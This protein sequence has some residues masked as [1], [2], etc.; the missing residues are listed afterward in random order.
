MRNGRMVGHEPRQNLLGHRLHD[1]TS[2]RS[3]ESMNA[4]IASRGV[5]PP[6]FPVGDPAECRIERNGERPIRPSTAPAPAGAQ[7]SRCPEPRSRSACSLRTCRSRSGRRARRAPATHRPAAAPRAHRAG[8]RAGPQPY[9]TQPG[10]PPFA[11]RDR[12]TLFHGRSPRSSARIWRMSSDVPSRDPF[13]ERSQLVARPR[14][15]PEKFRCPTVFPHQPVPL[16]S[17]RGRPRR[18]RA[19]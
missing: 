16:G 13:T 11:N 6:S 18:R 14:T 12:A 9:A 5:A 8:Q 17:C 7:G 4:P 3:T 19:P 15:K 1:L 10:S 2:Q